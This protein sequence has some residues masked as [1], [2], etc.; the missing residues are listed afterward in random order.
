MNILCIL[1]YTINIVL[2][3]LV[4]LPLLHTASVG[5]GTGGNVGGG[6]GGLGNAARVACRQILEK[7][8]F[9]CVIYS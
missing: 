7:T 3:N 5:V 8:P 4:C 9:V 6:L 2:K 1:V